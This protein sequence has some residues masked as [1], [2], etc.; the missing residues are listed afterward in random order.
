MIHPTCPICN[1]IQLQD[2]DHKKPSV[3]FVHC[4]TCDT[5]LFIERHHGYT[6][7]VS[8]L[9]PVGADVVKHTKAN[10]T[11]TLVLCAIVFYWLTFCSV[12]TGLSSLSPVLQVSLDSDILCYY[13][14]ILICGLLLPPI[15]ALFGLILA[16]LYIYG[17]TTGLYA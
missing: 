10:I 5:K 6:Y 11:Y 15:G 14:Y 2:T 16:C 7:T 17:Y 9:E 1:S 13:K 12:F 3:Y 4:D 8:K